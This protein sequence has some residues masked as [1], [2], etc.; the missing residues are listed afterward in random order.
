MCFDYFG[1]LK[2]AFKLNFSWNNFFIL[3][4][5][6]FQKLK[7]IF[8]QNSDILKNIQLACLLKLI[9]SVTCEIYKT[10]RAAKDI[11]LVTYGDTMRAPQL[12]SKTSLNK[13]CVAQAVIGNAAS[14]CL[15]PTGSSKWLNSFKSVLGLK[16]NNVTMNQ[17]K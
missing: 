3:L 10:K 7:C 6:H 9:E 15:A 14:T 1:S 13:G 4:S 17:Q 8:H 2:I 5:Y 16:N 11:D 12:G